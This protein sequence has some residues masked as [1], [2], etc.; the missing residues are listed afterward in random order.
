MDVDSKKGYVY[1]MGNESVVKLAVQGLVTIDVTQ[2]K[3]T[4]FIMRLNKQK[5]KPSELH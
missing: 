4:P 3:A 5:T 1:T 2:L